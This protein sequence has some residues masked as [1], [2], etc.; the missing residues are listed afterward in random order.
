MKK[1]IYLVSAII[2]ISLQSCEEPVNNKLLLGNWTAAA[3]L[4]NGVPQELDLKSINFSFYEDNTYRYQGLMNKEAG[5]YYLKRNLL[6]STDTLSNNRIE[7]SV[8]I[9]KSTTDSLFFEMNLG[10]IN[11][12]IK[13]YKTE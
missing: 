2:F 8:K 10:G 1:I 9:I 3:F 7:K 6:Y 13:L 11:Q 12:I 5:N 4:E